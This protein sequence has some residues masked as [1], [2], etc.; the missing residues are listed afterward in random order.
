[1]NHS[2]N[3]HTM[4]NSHG[5]THHSDLQEN[6]MNS[7][8][9]VVHVEEPVTTYIRTDSSGKYLNLSNIRPTTL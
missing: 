6:H 2:E 8:D 3:H 5:L 9:A 4:S 7:H 1:M